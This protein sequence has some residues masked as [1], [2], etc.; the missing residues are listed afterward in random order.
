MTIAL[1][2]KIVAVV[3]VSRLP[4]SKWGGVTVADV[5]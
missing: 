1:Y 5:Y 2:Q 3:H 4:P